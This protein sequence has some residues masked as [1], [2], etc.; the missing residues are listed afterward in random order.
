VKDAANLDGVRSGV[1]KEEPVVADA[2]PEF[3]SSLD[4]SPESSVA[5]LCMEFD[6]ADTDALEGISNLFRK[7]SFCHLLYR[8]DVRPR[9]HGGGYGALGPSY[10]MA[11]SHVA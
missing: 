4:L 11:C 1:D 10:P 3:L 6:L 2:K 5:L 7:A 9:G 8:M